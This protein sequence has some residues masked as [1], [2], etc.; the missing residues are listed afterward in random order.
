MFSA[1]T[2]MHSCLKRQ[3]MVNID[4]VTFVHHVSNPAGKTIT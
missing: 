4:G 3:V 2:K 1:L